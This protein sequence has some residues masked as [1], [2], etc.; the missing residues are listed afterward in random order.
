MDPSPHVIAE[1]RRIFEEPMKLLMVLMRR[2]YPDVSTAE[3]DWRMNCVL[4]ALVFSQVY[5]ERIGP[6]F[7]P[8]ADTDDAQT[9]S[10]ILHFLVNGA[11]AAAYERAK[12]TPLKSQPVSRRKRLSDGTAHGAR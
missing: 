5:S 7:G 1:M 9:S 3:L 4:G 10:W 12:V 8:E 11:G 6:F 2:A